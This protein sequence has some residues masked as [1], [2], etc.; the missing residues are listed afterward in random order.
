MFVFLLTAAFV[1]KRGRIWNSIVFTL[2]IISYALQLWWR[3]VKEARVN[4][5]Q[6]CFVKSM[7]FGG[8]RNEEFV[9]LRCVSCLLGNL[10]GEN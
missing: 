8:G 1:Q 4:W 10:V 3:L 5:F 9:E 6:T 2:S 7:S